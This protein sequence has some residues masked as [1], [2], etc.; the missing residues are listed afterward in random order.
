MKRKTAQGSL[1]RTFKIVLTYFREAVKEEKDLLPAF[2]APRSGEG[3]Q[4]GK[5]NAWNHPS[6][7]NLKRPPEAAQPRHFGSQLCIPSP[8]HRKGEAILT[9]GQKQEIKKNT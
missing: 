8:C 1:A 6:T 4:P 9:L 3:S 7:H 2:P 5:R